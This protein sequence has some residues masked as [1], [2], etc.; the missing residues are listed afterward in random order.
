MHSPW[1]S[2]AYFYGVGGA[3][4]V[5]SLVLILRTGAAQWSLRTDRRLI[6]ILVAGTVVSALFH[7]AWIVWS[8]GAGGL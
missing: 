5:F 6:K 8:S 4:L 1:L 3:L 7:A 2:W